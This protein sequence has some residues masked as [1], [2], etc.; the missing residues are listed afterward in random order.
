MSKP[1]LRQELES[2]STIEPQMAQ[3]RSKLSSL[4]S[5]QLTLV[6]RDNYFSKSECFLPDIGFVLPPRDDKAIG[7]D[8]VRPHRDGRIFTSFSTLRIASGGYRAPSASQ[9]RSR[10]KTSRIIAGIFFMV[11]IGL[12]G[13]SIGYGMESSLSSSQAQTITV[14][15]S[16]TA[17]N[18]SSSAASNSSQPFVLTLVVT[19]NNSYNASVG[20]QP[21][22][23][24]LGPHGLESA[25][26]IAVPAHQLIKLVII[27]Y[28]D[29]AANLTGS[30]YATVSGT[31]NNTVSFVSNT[32]VNSSQSASG[33]QVNGGQTIS[34]LPT[35]GIAHTFTIPQLGIN[36]PLAPASTTTAYITL[37]QTGSFTWLC[38]SLCGSGPTGVSGAMETP[39]WMTGNVVAT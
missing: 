10:V 22:Y 16:T 19:T 39:G 36:I 15:S 13:I 21:A 14:T 35:D 29:G 4:M 28:D 31:Q 23:Y 20:D 5:T 9:F 32:N 17:T 26:S 3:T 27:C 18:S 11:L 33:I 7:G 38:M 1:H 30:Q 34:S 12:S 25:A 8:E 6:R 24:V 2:E 37:D